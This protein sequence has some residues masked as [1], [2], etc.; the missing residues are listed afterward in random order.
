VWDDLGEETRAACGFGLSLREIKGQLDRRLHSSFG[1]RTLNEQVCEIAKLVARSME[2]FS[3]A[4]LN[5]QD[6]MAQEGCPLCRCARRAESG[7]LKSLDW[8]SIDEV[9]A[10]SGRAG[11]LPAPAPDV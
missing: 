3:L 9:G 1:L 8:E 10:R 5:L 6:A 7:L 11:I 4:L 2:T